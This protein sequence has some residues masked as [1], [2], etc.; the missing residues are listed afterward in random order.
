M[1]LPLCK[2]TR[3]QNTGVSAENNESVFVTAANS[4]CVVQTGCRNMAWGGPA[5]ASLA[6][7]PAQAQTRPWQ[8]QTPTP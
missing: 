7:M 4:M 1:L 2:S 3:P 6:V 8:S 5:R